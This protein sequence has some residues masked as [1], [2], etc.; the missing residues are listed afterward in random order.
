PTALP[1]R[2]A[3]RS[4]RGPPA[5][6]SSAPGARRRYRATSEIAGRRPLPIS[7]ERL[8][9]N[10]FRGRPETG[11]RGLAAVGCA[12]V[13]GDDRNEFFGNAVALER[14]GFLS[15]DEHGRNWNFAGT[16]QRYADIREL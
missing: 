15:V 10:R 11:R 2:A 14:H 8:H 5:A 16:R 1:R 6:L 13:V 12:N 7:C 3:R 4:C 9:R